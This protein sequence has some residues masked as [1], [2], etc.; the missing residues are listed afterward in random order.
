MLRISIMM[1]LWF[2]ASLCYYGLTLNLSSL[3]PNPNVSLCLSGLVEIPAYILA[4]FMME[5]E[6]FGR[7]RTTL[8]FYFCAFIGCFGT[9]FAMIESE[10]ADEVSMSV[11]GLAL[12]GK[13]AIAA[14][15][16]MIYI[17]TGELF[18]SD[19]RSGTD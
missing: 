11:L 18:P 5:R 10:S 15:F 14:A 3:H 2:S 4:Y 1:F 12:F 19:I 13:L 16:S 9:V 7:K 6:F 17:Y 8:F